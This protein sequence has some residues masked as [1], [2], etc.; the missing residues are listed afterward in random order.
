MSRVQNMA[1][2][3]QNISVK[4]HEFMRVCSENKFPICFEGDDEKYY[5]IRIDS[6]TNLDW[7][8]IKC[9]GKDK[10]IALRETIKASEAYCDKGVLFFIDS[11]FDT[12]EEVSGFTDV[13]VTPCYSIENLYISERAFVKILRSEFS[14]SE[15]DENPQN[16]VNVIRIFNERKREFLELITDFNLLIHSLRMKEASGELTTRLNI[17][18]IDIDQLVSISLTEVKKLYTLEKYQELFPE[19]P[20]DLDLN[21]D[22]SKSYFDGKSSEIVFRGKQNLDFLRTFILLLRQDR[23]KRCDREVFSESG[24]VKLQ[25]TKVNTLSELSQYADTPNCLKQFLTVLC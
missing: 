9:G 11:D 18:N 22:I 25:L 19:L 7:I 5:S 8:G 12:N 24:K 4:Y 23:G 3:R 20:D 1:Q 6:L 2:A 13:Y 14:I 21:L 10:V 17:N 15:V 16:Y